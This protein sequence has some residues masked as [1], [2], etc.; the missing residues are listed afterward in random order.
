[1]SQVS[2]LLLLSLCYTLLPEY[3]PILEKVE[4]SNHGVGIQS[5]TLLKSFCEEKGEYCTIKSVALNCTAPYTIRPYYTT[6]TTTLLLP[7]YMFHFV[8]KEIFLHLFCLVFGRMS[9][10]N[11]VARLPYLIAIFFF[12]EESSEKQ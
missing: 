4:F 11:I 1:M 5:L 3:T 7:L 9:S 6:T 2:L 8:E 12:F 10:V